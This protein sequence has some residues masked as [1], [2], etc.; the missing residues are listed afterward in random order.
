MDVNGPKYWEPNRSFDLNSHPTSVNKNLLQ[1]LCGMVGKKIPSKMCAIVIDVGT[2]TCKIGYAGQTQPI[3]IVANVVG[4]QSKKQAT[5][6]QSKVQTFIGEAAHACPQLTLMQLVCNKIVVDWEAAD[7]ICCHILENDLQVATLDH[8]L[9]FTDPPFNPA[10]NSEKLVEV[11]ESLY[12]PAIYVAFQSVLSVY[13]NGCVNGLVLDT[14]HR[15]SYTVPVL[16][17]YNLPNGIQR[18]GLAGHNLTTFLAEKI[19]RS[20]FLLKK[21]DTDIVES[22]KHQFCYVTS[23][24][25]KEQGHPD[26]K[27]QRCLKLPDGQMVTAGKELFQCP[28]LLCH[29][30]ETL[31][32]SS[33]GLHSMVEQSL[34]SMPQELRADMEQNVLLC[35]GSSLFPGFESHFKDELQRCLCPQDQV[36]EAAHP[37]RNLSV[38]I[39]GSILA[40]LCAFQSRWILRE[41]YNKQD[42]NIVHRKCS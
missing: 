14:G 40:S 42:P 28:E 27:F 25:Q 6:G 16:Q 39:G 38:W 34:C 4:C 1:E 2:G 33:L 10:C 17:G 26:A 41:Q 31:G 35:G 32:P 36:F 18:L 19:L 20:S 21:K 15:V 12:S 9:L 23:D 30:P 13:D 3:Y 11:F 5:M 7:L 37:N 22:I 8:P 24:F 29:P